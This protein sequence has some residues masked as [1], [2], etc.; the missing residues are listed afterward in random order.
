MRYVSKLVQTAP[1]RRHY[2]SASFPAAFVRGGTSNGLIIDRRVLPKDVAQWQPILAS[3]MGSPDSYGRQLNGIG[4]GISSTS[5]ICVIERSERKGIDVDFTFVQVGIKDGAL[6]MAGNC[7]NMSAAVGPLAWDLGMMNDAVPSGDSV[8]ARIFNTNTSKEMHASFSVDEQSGKYQP[9]GD[10]SIDGVPGTA[11]KITISFLQP[12]GAKTGKAFPT[13]NLIDELALP[14]G[15][16]IRAT[17]SDVANPGVF[18]LAADLGIDG[19]TTP[20]AIGADAGLMRQLE[21][22]RRAGTSMMGLDPNV[23]SVP[24]IVLLQSPSAAQ[25]TNGVNIVCRALSMQQP[26]KAVPLTLALNLGVIALFEGTLAAEVARNTA[27]R[28]S[29]VI[30]H[31]SGMVEIGSVIREGEIETAELHRTARVLMRGDV[32][33]ETQD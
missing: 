32:F 12:G 11:S 26:H 27:G 25:L 19:N 5:K 33:Y 16:R 31:A 7:G 14:S 4:S 17:L 21:E 3:A 2:S 24:K 8:T 10:Y 28:T 9:M 1:S 20:D 23:Q 13:G 29:V 18:V 6:D 22:I 30:E 15:Q